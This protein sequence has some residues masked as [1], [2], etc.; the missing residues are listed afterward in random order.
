MAEDREKPGKKLLDELKDRVRDFIED[1]VEA[2]EDLA[3]PPMTPVPVRPGR[4]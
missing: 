2:V 4:R 1:L 3:R